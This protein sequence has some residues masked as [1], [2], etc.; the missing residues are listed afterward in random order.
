[1]SGPGHPGDGVS[2]RPRSIGQVFL[3]FAGLALRGFGGVL[4]WAQR[5]LVEERR[6]LTRE[7]FVEALAVGQVLPGPNICNLAVIVGDRWFGWR[8][9]LAALGGLVAAPA[10]LALALAALHGQVAGHPLAQRMLAGMG[11]AAG[12]LI[13][14]TA[15]RLATAQRAR[16]RWLGFGVIA[17]VGVGLLRMSLVSVLPV[18]GVVAV[19][20]AW[21]SLRGAGRG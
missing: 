15:V 6:W 3:V 19:C 9:A 2:A 8:G 4:P 12:G 7:A 5:V 14:A 17:F 21:W 18:V 20:A 10:V 16:W 11:A 13:L 1:M